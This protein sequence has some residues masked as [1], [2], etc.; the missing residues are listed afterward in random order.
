M[1][2]ETDIRRPTVGVQAI[3]TARRQHRQVLLG[4]RKNVY[5]DGQW[6]FPGGHL[7][8][9]ES[10]EDAAARELEEE[11][12]LRATEMCVWKSINTPYEHTHYV[13]IGVQVVS[14]RGKERNLEPDRC[15]NLRWWSLDGLPEPLFPPS[16][17]FLEALRARDSLPSL[18]DVE[19]NLAIFMFKFDE[20]YNS[21]TYTNYLV[22]GCPPR[23]LVRR[24]RR[25]E[26]R[27]RGGKHYSVE[28]H[29]DAKDILKVDIARNL[30]RGYV[31]YDVRG[32]FSVEWVRSLF[33]DGTVAFRALDTLGRRPAED[34]MAIH[35]ELG[36]KFAQL[37]LF[38][39]ADEAFPAVAVDTMRLMRNPCLG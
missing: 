14:F 17:P 36:R 27:D 19:P 1:N 5:G 4:M 35:R 32:N 8:F 26:K 23:I 24:G 7:E 6:A 30:N 20:L 33:P 12:G 9:G 16:V 11:T 31:L 34:E 37:T 28:S 18:R 13:Q 3:V 25:G 29:Q 21:E 22:L 2:N 10:F 39:E 15:A 38:E